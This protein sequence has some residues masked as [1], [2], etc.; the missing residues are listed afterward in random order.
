[1]PDI[2]HLLKI[3]APLERVYQALTTAEDIRH[4]WTRDAV[5][6]SKIGGTGEFRFYES[7]FVT[8]IKVDELK[9]P[10][11]VG[12]KTISSFRPEWDGTTLTFDLRAEGNN[13]V[14]SFAQR[15]FEQADEVYALTTT[16]WAYYLVSLQQY[17]E[18][19]NGAPH[20]DI[21][22]ARIIR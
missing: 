13:T 11:H 20:P 22:F 14:L 1:M 5:L 21:D 10:V 8:K 4:W 2:M 9:M 12:W 7:K 18:T 15:G 16:G 6:D 3:H 17:L 19:G